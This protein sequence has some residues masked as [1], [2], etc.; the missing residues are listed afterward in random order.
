LPSQVTRFL[1]RN[2]VEAPWHFWTAGTFESKLIEAIRAG[3][4]VNVVLYAQRRMHGQHNQVI[5]GFVRYGSTNYFMVSDA[6]FAEKEYDLPRGN[7]LLS[8]YELTRSFP[9]YLFGVG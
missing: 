3:H 2:G 7:V 6:Q 5:S 1:R 8:T 9:K 4:L